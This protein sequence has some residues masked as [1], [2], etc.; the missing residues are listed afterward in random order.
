MLV[1]IHFIKKGQVPRVSQSFVKII[2][3][4]NHPMTKIQ[5]LFSVS[6]VVFLLIP[7]PPIYGWIIYYS[8]FCG[9]DIL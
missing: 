1:R 2:I 6:P 4:A 5:G 9:L 7:R 8:Y 3:Y